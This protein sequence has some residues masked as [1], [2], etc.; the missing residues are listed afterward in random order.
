MKPSGPSE[1]AT[2]P[3][4]PAW[5][6]RLLVWFCP[7]ELREELL[8]DLHEQFDQQVEEFGQAK[9]QRLYVWEIIRFC[10]PYFLKRRVSDAFKPQ[11]HPTNKPVVL[12][13]QPAYQYTSSNYP[14]PAITDMLRNYLKIALRNLWRNRGLTS[15]NLLGLSTGIACSL[16]ILLF[17]RHE[18]SYD[19]F[20]TDAD[21]IYRVVKDFVND[22]GSRLPDATTPPALAPALQREMPEVERVTRVFPNWGANYLIRYDDKQFYEEGL[23]RVDSSFFDVFTFPF[24][25]GAPKE[26]FRQLNSI[27]LTETMAHKYFGAQNPMGKVLKVG[28]LGD[29]MVSGVLGDVP[30]T[31][32]FH[33]DFLISTRKIG[34]NIDT[35]WGFYNFYTYIKL[36]AGA[37]IAE[38]EPKIQA[39]YKRNNREATNQFYTQALIDIH[40][41]SNLKWE[42]A[43]NSD[44][45]YIYV[46]TVL[47]LF[48][49]LIA[50]INYVNLATAKSS[51]R[52]KEVGV[53]K[54]SGAV[55]SSLIQQ[56]LIESIIICLLSAVVAV[57]FAQV[58]LPLVNELTQKHLQLLNTA[59]V[60]LFGWILLTAM[61][62]GTIA[63][64]F[65]ALYLSSFKPV[66]VLKGLKLKEKGI[67]TI[68]K[69]LVVV[70]FTISIVLVAGALII[71]KQMR[72]IQSARLG[73]NKEQVLIIRDAGQMPNATRSALQQAIRQL[74]GVGKVATSDGIVGGQNWTN[75]MRAK[76]SD[77][78]QLVNFLSVGYD[79][80]D[81]M[82]MQIKEGRNFSAA[83]PADT[84]TNGAGK[85]LD[86]TIGSTILNERAVKE[87]GVAK[88][89]IGQKI[90]WGRDGDTTYYLNLVG[91]VKD[92]HF[93]SL[94]SEIKPFAFVNSPRRQLYFTVKLATD[95]VSTTLAQLENQ[96]QTFVPDR[97]IQYS[98]L[99]ETFAKLYMAERRF[100][101]VFT[102][103]VGLGIFI[104]C[105]GLFA[106]SAFTAEQR[107]KEIGIRKV[108]GASVGSIVT[109]LAQ[110][111]L[112]LVLIAV[113]LAS[114]LAWWT[115]SR[116]LQDF[117][118][119][120][121]IEWWV[122][123]LAGLLAV[124]IALLT[125]SFQSIKA[126]LVNPVKSL[127]AE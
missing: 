63:G 51:L 118:Y 10:R 123:A 98:F 50:A 16:L 30:E 103:L 111:F 112:K 13:R 116:W 119:K 80:L 125:V 52:A 40:L 97:P 14:T 105:M 23:Y 53:R 76:G 48:I 90:V 71:S 26:A 3:A 70:Q 85:T 6:D 65:P 86:Q 89:L 39:L 104:A 34:G 83:F 43:P 56:F 77:K 25:Q 92:F 32:H 100:Q 88:P 57:L 38:L 24:V 66:I 124:G 58:F 36:K 17:V 44:R 28:N 87:L 81:V 121:T 117:A 94:R 113:L 72:F 74:S 106:L 27:V 46:F 60:T 62:I 20:H 2:R 64:L 9:A 22:D 21:R 49:L 7:L 73:L 67:L 45:L 110:D 101:A 102:I 47:G 19:R 109:L 78:E 5:A 8:G 31:S 107:T 59:N 37:R 120:I 96:W 69:G 79:F 108:L 127:K 1:D 82:G 91:V 114:P 115:M 29:L 4:P 84:L 75:G 41:T 122:F 61:L 55:K 18:L 95:K 54:V 35:D 42:L 99:D 15:I 126:A 93:T 12:G 68:R 33:F 11:A